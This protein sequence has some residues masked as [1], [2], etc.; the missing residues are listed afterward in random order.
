MF[1]VPTLQ[2]LRDTGCH[3]IVSGMASIAHHALMITSSIM[4]PPMRMGL[5]GSPQQ[6][7]NPNLALAQDTLCYVLYI[8]LIL[9]LCGGEN[10]TLWKPR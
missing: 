6:Q 10:L 2:P 8:G 5:T 9:I 4:W 7:C 1:T 3:A